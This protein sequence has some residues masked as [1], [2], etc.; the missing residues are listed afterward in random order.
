LEY[1]VQDAAEGAVMTLLTHHGSFWNLFNFTQEGLDEF[2]KKAVDDLNPFEL[3]VPTWLRRNG[4]TKHMLQFIPIL[5]D[6][7][8]WWEI[9]YKYCTD[10][11]NI[12]YPEQDDVLKDSKVVECYNHLSKYV[13]NL[14]HY[15]ELKDYKDPRRELSKLIAMYMHISCIIHQFSGAGTYILSATPYRISLQ[16]REGRQLEEKISSVYAAIRARNAAFSTTIRAPRLYRDW[17]YMAPPKDPEGKAAKLMKG[18][19]DEMTAIGKRID[20]RNKTR[21]YSTRGLHPDVL[22]CSVSV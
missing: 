20:A 21:A 12:F 2:C 3:H 10:Y 15:P 16:W 7:Y 9:M 18:F 4:I 5:Q 17:S 22:G 8:D 13:K 6:A 14:V 19:Y 11:I 1:G